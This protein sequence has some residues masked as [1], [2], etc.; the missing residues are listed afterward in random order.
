MRLRAA[1]S[2][3]M[4]ALALVSALCIVGIFVFNHYSRQTDALDQQALRLAKDLAPAVAQFFTAN[5]QAKL[6]PEALIAGGLKIPAPLKLQVPPDHEKA[7]DWQVRLWHPEG[8]Q[9]FTI[10]AA[11]ITQKPR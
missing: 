5:P 9:V 10:S 1:G 2:Y 8:T 11:G 6:T 4:E 3:T 7:P